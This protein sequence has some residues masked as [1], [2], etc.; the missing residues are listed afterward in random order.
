MMSPTSAVLDSVLGATPT[1]RLT[2]SGSMETQAFVD[3]I[4]L[5]RRIGLKIKSFT[6]RGQIWDLDPP[7]R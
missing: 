7:A 4:L 6:F 2:P 1:T 5:T 3:A